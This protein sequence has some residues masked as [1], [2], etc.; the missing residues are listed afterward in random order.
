VCTD[1]HSFEGCSIDVK[2]DTLRLMLKK[3]EFDEFGTMN[4]ETP[5]A[6]ELEAFYYMIVNYSDFIL[7]K[8]LFSVKLKKV[9][10]LYNG[11]VRMLEDW[12]YP[13]LE[14]ELLN[15]YIKKKGML[16]YALIKHLI[17]VWVSFITGVDKQE[18]NE[19]DHT[20]LMMTTVSRQFK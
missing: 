9:L 19:A 16:N 5:T 1:F 12:Q 2:H 15:V 8:A 10:D 6:K 14:N 20:L 18:Y 17:R 7:K 13:I 3:Y 4:A 11:D